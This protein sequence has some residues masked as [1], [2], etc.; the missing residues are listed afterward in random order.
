M[1]MRS[2]KRSQKHLN[3]YKRYADLALGNDN[4]VAAQPT[5]MDT[6]HIDNNDKISSKVD[7]D[8]DDDDDDVI[9]FN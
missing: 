7:N 6:T 9:D 1:K 5:N 4:G 8:D 3:V 2:K